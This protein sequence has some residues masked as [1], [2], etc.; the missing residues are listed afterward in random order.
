[1]AEKTRKHS[2]VIPC[3]S[4]F[5]DAILHLAEAR[6]VNVGDL[7]RSVLLVVPRA[8][9]AACPDPGEPLSEDREVVVLKSGPN[10]GRPWRRKPRLQ[11]R[12]PKGYEVEDIRRALG[13]ALAFSTGEIAVGLEDGRRPNARAR[14]RALN[15]EIDRL[16]NQLALVQ[17]PPLPHGVRNRAEALFVLGYP[18]SATPTQAELKAR[19]RALATVHHPD[20]PFGDT[21]RMSQLNQAMTWLR[22]GA[23]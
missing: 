17:P 12:L 14:I 9:V 6:A 11:A 5:R 13:L 7:A 18:S 8:T 1:M 23:A 21:V 16:R 10:S 19:F 2:Y 15:S 20:A 4:G 22:A 3:S